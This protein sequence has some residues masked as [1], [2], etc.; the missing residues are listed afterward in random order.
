MKYMIVVWS[1][2]EWKIVHYSNTYQDVERWYA[3]YK[4][5]YVTCRLMLTYEHAVL[6]ENSKDTMDYITSLLKKA[7][8]CTPST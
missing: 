4:N 2:M 8:E 1:D 3:Y 5:M 7:K 6:A